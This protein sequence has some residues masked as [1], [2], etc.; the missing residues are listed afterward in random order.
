VAAT[1]IPRED[2]DPLEMSMGCYLVQTPDRN[3]LI[4]TGA[5]PEL[6]MPGAGPGTNV[7]Q[8]LEALGLGPGDVD[9][10]VS[11]HLDVDHVGHH[12]AF[13]DAEHVVQRSQY[14]RA[15]SGH[16][17]FAGGRAH[18]DHP[19][20]RYRLVEGDTELLP[21]LT[22]IE[23]GGHTVGHQSVLVRLP[24]TGPVLLAVDA[25]A[26]AQQFILERTLAPVDEDLEGLVAST[27][28]LLDL[29]ESEGV[30]MVVF[31]HDGSQWRSLRR[32]PAYYD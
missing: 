14:E 26:L 8:H 29:V 18:W 32:S 19:A 13:P 12:D 11:S 21:G 5:P 28:R 27:R 9:I 2:G 7:L 20:L 6:R 30:K 16:P 31:H 23:T 22:L 15:R 25:V 17:R 1:T 10:V 24:R 3:I 4:D